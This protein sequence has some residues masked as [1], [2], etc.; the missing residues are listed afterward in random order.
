M[1]RGRGHER[2][3]EGFDPT[4]V[5]AQT[6]VEQS[7]SWTLTRPA[8]TVCGD[9]R[10]EPPWH[11]TFRHNDSNGGLRISVEEAAILQGFRRDY[12]FQG[13]RSAKFQQV[14]N[15]VPPPLAAAV[16]RQV[17]EKGT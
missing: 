7:R 17:I 12:P 16:L 4:E 9:P 10:I 6:L 2:G 3:D 15:A 5:P 8:T 11:H 1:R 14:G 13:T